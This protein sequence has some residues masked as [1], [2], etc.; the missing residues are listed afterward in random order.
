MTRYKRVLVAA[1]ILVGVAGCSSAGNTPA[2]DTGTSASAPPG[3][4]GTYPDADAVLSALQ[5]QGAPCAGQQP[6]ANPT[7]TG[8][9]SMVDC[10]SPAGG[11]DTV[12]VVFDTQAHALAYA[13]S[14]TSGAL[15]GISSDAVVVYGRDW[16]VNTS[17]TAY[18][19]TVRRVLGGQVV[20][21]PS[22]Q[23]S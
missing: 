1:A 23:A 10:S 13:V 6:V 5:A 18:A 7:L 12:V 21:A 14:L 4:G 2:A 9:L 16:A 11:S 3:D 17:S 19:D 8:A 20:A 15:S 22:A